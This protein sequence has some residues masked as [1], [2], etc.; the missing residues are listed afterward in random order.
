MLEEEV[1]CELPKRRE[2]MLL[3]IVYPVPKTWHIIKYWDV[4]VELSDLIVI[5][6]S[7]IDW[8]ETRG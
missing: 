5:K 2:P 1:G 3:T 8:T 7:G 6:T 4:Y